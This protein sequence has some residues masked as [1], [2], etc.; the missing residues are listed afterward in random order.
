MRLARVALFLGVLVVNPL[1]WL[2]LLVVQAYLT[3]DC[4]VRPVCS[5]WE[6]GRFLLLACGL[7]LVLNALEL[8]AWRR[9]DE[10]LSAVRLRRE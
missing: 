6:A 8:V 1:I 7:A 5:G 10:R 9:L 4:A 2:V 3:G